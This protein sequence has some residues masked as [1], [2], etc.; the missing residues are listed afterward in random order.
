MAADRH[1]RITIETERILIIARQHAKRE[2]CKECGHE[3]EVLPLDLARALLENT[4]N[5]FEE[6]KRPSCHQWPA[7][8]GLIFVCIRSLLRFLHTGSGRNNS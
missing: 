7:K 6:Q 3:V 8:D 2:W 1:T 4:T 5:S